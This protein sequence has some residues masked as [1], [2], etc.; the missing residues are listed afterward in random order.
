MTY[1]E[2]V[3][4]A[5][6]RIRERMRKAD[7]FDVVVPS[8]ISHSILFAD[9]NADKARQVAAIAAQVADLV[10]VLA[11]SAGMTTGPGDFV[12]DPAGE[13]VYLYTGKDAMT[14]SNPTYYPGATGVYYWAIV[15]DMHKG[16]KV[17]PNMSGTVVFVKKDELWWNP[18]KTALYKWN[19]ADFHCPAHQYPGAAG[20]HS[21]VKAE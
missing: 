2:K 19:A 12:R 16:H 18:G 5:A 7:S 14:H 1:K 20:V 8:V 9:G 17:F 10:T 6:P 11:W 15:P 3:Q 21:W 13:R 4:A